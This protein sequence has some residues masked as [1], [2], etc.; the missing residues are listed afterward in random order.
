MTTQ[1]QQGL[2]KG[3]GG[4]LVSGRHGFEVGGKEFFQD[5]AHRR[6]I[7]VREER[8][9]GADADILFRLAGR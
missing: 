2:A 5:R 9:D 6:A 3:A 1:D 7:A 4:F 8:Q